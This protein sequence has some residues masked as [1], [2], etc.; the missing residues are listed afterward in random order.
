MIFQFLI[1]LTMS[2]IFIIFF[3]SYRLKYTWPL[4]IIFLKS[5]FVL[6]NFCQILFSPCISWSP[7]HDNFLHQSI[8]STLWRLSFLNPAFFWKWFFLI[9]FRGLWKIS[10][11]FP[12][13]YI[14]ILID[15]PLLTQRNPSLSPFIFSYVSKYIL[16]KLTTSI[17]AVLLPRIILT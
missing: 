4:F 16:L 9:L 5:N 12:I 10:L 17:T 7:E 2:Q 13:F 14:Y 3:Y 11:T 1:L 8:C 15:F 6:F